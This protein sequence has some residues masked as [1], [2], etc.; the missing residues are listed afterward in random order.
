[1]RRARI[2][3]LAVSGFALVVVAAGWARSHFAGDEIGYTDGD[4]SGCAFDHGAGDLVLVHWSKDPFVTPASTGWYRRRNAPTPVRRN[5]PGRVV[6]LFG[7]G[8]CLDR[9]FAEYHAITV[10]YGLVFTIAATPWLMVAWRYWRQHAA[11]RIA[12]GLCPACGYDLRASPDHC[13][14][15]GADAP[16]TRPSPA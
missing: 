14:E 3:L 11:R 16:L 9:S 2:I 5:L 6:G 13:P 4:A 7:Y 10:P 8:L 15:C 1:V 12:A